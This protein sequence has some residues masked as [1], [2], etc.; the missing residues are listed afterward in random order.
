MNKIIAAVISLLYVGASVTNA[1]SGINQLIPLAILVL[2]LLVI[3]VS[4]IG[5]IM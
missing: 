4:V 5:S 3:V 2:L 1:D